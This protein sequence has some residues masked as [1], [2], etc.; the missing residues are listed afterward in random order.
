MFLHQP[1]C[2]LLGIYEF[3]TD[4]A[5]LIFPLLWIVSCVAVFFSPDANSWLLHQSRLLND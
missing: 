3:G 2:I 4:Y 1:M 5:S